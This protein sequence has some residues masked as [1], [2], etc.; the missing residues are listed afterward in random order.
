MK[1][2]RIGINYSHGDKFQILRKHGSG[3]YLFI[4]TRSSA[5][6]EID[7]EEIPAKK[8]SAIIYKMG[9]RQHYYADKT[10]YSNDF[11]HFSLEND[12]DFING[13]NLTFDKIFRPSNTKSI[14]KILKLL[15]IEY[16]SAD[17]DKEK[18]IDLLL[19]LL[20]VKLS[21]SENMST[22]VT[23]G[24]NY[25]DKLNEIRSE[26]YQNPKKNYTVDELSKKANLSPSYFQHIYKDAFK[27]SCIND[28]INSKIEYSK[29]LL[30]SSDYLVKEISFLCG[31][32]NDVH[33][34][35]QFKRVAGISPS[36]Y[37]QK[38]K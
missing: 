21:S 14:N 10:S 35:R 28:V 24:I 32:E 38:Y 7:G 16:Y 20:F 3:D 29:S 26:I 36:E 37:R 23:H 33:F 30:V 15:N 6:F 34:M 31:Y 9:T 1:I 4:L 13:L 12:M 11:I 17:N 5:I 18:S 27:I 2:N 25:Y 19:K 8:Y 22:S